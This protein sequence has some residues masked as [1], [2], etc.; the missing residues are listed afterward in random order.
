MD[1]GPEQIND[2]PMKVSCILNRPNM[3]EYEN[4]LDLNIVLMNLLQM[5]FSCSCW[6]DVQ[7]KCEDDD[8]V[9]V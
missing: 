6:K 4:R 3:K 9:D 8:H 2:V 7:H 5:Y 1:P